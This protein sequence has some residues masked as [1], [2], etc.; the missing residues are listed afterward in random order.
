ME[1]DNMYIKFNNNV[2]KGVIGHSGQVTIGEKK[3]AAQ[4]R[5]EKLEKEAS[6]TDTV[7]AL[8]LTLVPDPIAIKK[9]NAHKEAMK[10]LGDV[11]SSQLKTDN[12]IATHTDRMAE[13]DQ[14]ALSAQA[15]LDKLNEKKSELQKEY[16]GRTDSPEYIQKALEI[17][18]AATE[19][20]SRL[21]AAK[22]EKEGLSKAVEGIH[23]ALL[24]AD[25]MVGAKK[26]AD[27]IMEAANKDIISD[28]VDDTKDSIDDK[29]EEVVEKAQEKKEE[30]QEEEEKQVEREKKQEQLEAV[31]DDIKDPKEV[32]VENQDLTNATDMI[33]TADSTQSKIENEI[34]NLIKNQQLI[35]EDLKGLE[36]DQL[37]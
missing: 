28:I 20:N 19:F 10:K 9:R 26:A 4:L 34:K 25:P 31:Q 24:K 1:G 8:D 7:N 36:I 16:E 32:A 5:Q 11:F 21:Q 23:L 12:E 3:N 27:K 37:L 33:Q 29:M 35:E 14:E 2:E 13:L 6:K 18:K 17:D 22:S 30:K 15:E